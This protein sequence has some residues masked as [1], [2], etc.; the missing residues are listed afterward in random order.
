MQITLKEITVREL[1]DG[2]EDNAEDGVVGYGGKLDIRPPYQREFIYGPK[3]RDAVINTVTNN[4]PL[5]VMYWAVRKDGNFEVIDGQQRT[6]SI[7]QYV[8]GIFSFQK[9]YFENL[10]DDRQEKILNYKLT[11]YQCTG[12]DSERLDWFR[13]IN[14]AGKP[15]TDQELK[16]AVYAGS[17]VSDAKRYFSKTGCAAYQIGQDYLNGAPIRQDY[18]ETAIDWI[19]DSKIEEYMGRHQHDKNAT[20]LWKYYQAVI[21]WVAATFTTKRKNIMRGVPWGVLYNE[22]KGKKHDPKAIEAETMKLIEDDEVTNQKG[23]Y[24]YIL[25]RDEKYLSLRTFNDKEKQKA[26]EKQKGI[27][28]KC[29]KKKR[30]ELEEM[31]ADHISPWHSGGRTVQENCQMLCK[32]HNRRKSGQ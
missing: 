1:A 20:K 27:C 29:P 8:K 26:Y 28:P 30:W 23:I 22:F 2:Y 31:E 5:N 6:I 3:E 9:L 19:S 21:E 13:T 32:D 24:R 18:L 4:F 14:I 11:V 17:W 15:L 25:T 12:T 16:N 7:C 10:P